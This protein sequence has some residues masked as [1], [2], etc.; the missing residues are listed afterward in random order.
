V[1]AVLTA[2]PFGGPL[3]ERLHRPGGEEPRLYWLGQAGFAVLARGRCILIDPYLSDSLA[4]KYRGTATPHDRLMAAPVAIADLPPVDLILVTHHHTDHMDAATLAPIAA[5]NPGVPILV[6]RAS[7]HRAQAAIGAS[8]LVGVDAGE[9]HRPLEG[10]AIAVMRAA[11]ETLERDA[12]GCHRFLGY[13]VDLSGSRIL[14]SGDTVPFEGQAAEVAAFAP[15]V[16]LLPVNGRSAELAARGIAGNMTAAEAVALCAEA[17][18]PTMLAHHYGMFAFNTA[19]PA[20]IDHVAAAE[21]RVAVLRAQTGV[22]YRL[23]AA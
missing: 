7:L 20:E 4:D 12:D 3:A 11:H 18:V 2:H 8:T 9:R 17:A 1:T 19:D 10:V 22:E 16:A 21:R 13:S 14:H 15:H 6:P 23:G 5:R